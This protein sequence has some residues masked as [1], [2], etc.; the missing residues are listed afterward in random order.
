[1]LTLDPESDTPLVRQITVGLQALIDAGKLAP[2]MKLPSIRVFAAKHGVSTFTVVEAYDRLVANGVLMVQPH[3]GF[4]IRGKEVAASAPAPVL[5]PRRHSFD[6]EWYIR[7]IFENRSLEMKPGCGWL[8][9]DWL[10]ED[11]LRRAMRHVA[12][13]KIVMSGYGDPQGYAGLREH[14]ARQMSDDRQVWTTSE[15]VLLTQGSSQALDLVMRTLVNPGDAVLVD[16]PGYPNLFEMLRAYGARPVGVPRLPRDYDLA[17]MEAAIVQHKP[18][19]F[20]TQAR[21]HSPTGSRILGAPLHRMLRLAEDHGIWVIENDIFAELDPEPYTGLAT[22]DQLRRVVVVGSFS[23]TISPNV[24]T[25]YAVA[26]TSVLQSMVELKMRSGLTSPDVM[27][28]IVH[29]VVTGARWRKHLRALQ[30]RLHD[31]HQE[32]EARLDAL[33]FEVFCRPRAGLYIWAR[34]ERLSDSIDLVET[35]LT[36]GIMLGPGQLFSVQGTT[37]GCIRF[38]VAHSL[39]PK[40]WDFMAA[41]IAR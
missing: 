40:L 41:Q 4:F 14:I 18:V 1:M 17:A 27:E 7:R 23:K 36:R 5:A 30:Q 12:S 37:G 35:A 19:A 15:Q 6:S 9:G 28:R 20:F 31:A 24:R 39:S 33:G 21:L 25:G 8:P 3:R 29:A 2:G 10:F 32:V 16:D 26:N 11:G 13:D 34:H 38:N 22:L